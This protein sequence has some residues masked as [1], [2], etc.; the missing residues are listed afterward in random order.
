MR[1]KHYSRVKIPYEYI[2]A[3]THVTSRAFED[4]Q[5]ARMR[6]AQE[7]REKRAEV[8]A[9]NLIQTVGGGK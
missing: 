8:E 3:S 5:R 4:R 1:P 6:V 2:P 7:M 9:T